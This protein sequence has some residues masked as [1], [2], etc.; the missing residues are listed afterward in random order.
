M[1]KPEIADCKCEDKCHQ[2]TCY[3]DQQSNLYDLFCRKCLTNANCISHQTQ[4][5][6]YNE[7]L[8]DINDNLYHVGRV[9]FNVPLDTL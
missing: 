7:V 8:Y 9:W 1:C 5:Y 3:N 4:V 6:G 2:Q